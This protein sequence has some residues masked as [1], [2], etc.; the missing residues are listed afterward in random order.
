MS[1]VAH[2]IEKLFGDPPTH[3]LK[4]I[5]FEIQT[6]EFVSLTGRSGS[7]KSTLL[8]ILSSLDKPTRG[9]VS[10]SGLSLDQMSETDLHL[11]RNQKIGF[12]FQFHFL[13][14]ELSALE[15]VLMPA[16]KLKQENEKRPYAI[17]LLKQFG[18]EDRI[19]NLPHQLSGGEMQRVAIARAL[20]MSPEFIFADE[21]TGN[22]D[23]ANGELVMRI[24][25]DINVK[26]KTTIVMVTHDQEFAKNASRQI[27][28]ADGKVVSV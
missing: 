19:N 5:N 3:V 24:F 16:R 2:N 17:D 22:L 23:S 26:N 11:F 25:H 9:D 14:P 4:G 20:V 6:G 10:L 18:L 27:H 7:G 21:P 15:N 1:I 12:V 8:Y 13:L 28:L